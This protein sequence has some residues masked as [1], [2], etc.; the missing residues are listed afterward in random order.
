[1][2]KTPSIAVIPSGYKGAVSGE[3]GTVYS[4]LPTNGDA[5]LDFTRNCV[6]TRVNQNGLLE[7][8]GLNV[9][10]LDYSDGGCPSLL[11]EPSSTNLVPYS[12]DFSQWSK[13][14][15]NGTVTIVSNNILSPKGENNATRVTCNLVDAINN[16]RA[17][18]QLYV[19][20]VGANLSISIYLK[21]DNEDSILLRN[22][23]NIGQ[24]Q[25]I[26]LTKEWKRYDISVDNATIGNVRVEFGLRILGGF[27]NT[28]ATFDVFGVQLE[29]LPYA[30]S[31]IP[32][33]GTIE[34]RAKDAAS[35]S[36]L[37]NYINSSEGV[38]YAE[39]K[40]LA[41]SSDFRIISISDNSTS[42]RYAIGFDNL[43]RVYGFSTPSTLGG[44]ITPTDITEYFKVA[45]SFK[46]GEQKL[47]INGSQIGSTTTLTNLPTNLN[48]IGFDSGSG[49]S[50]LY[51]KVK[52]LR[53]YTTVLTD[54]ELTDLTS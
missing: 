49:G 28:S 19:A 32:T 20:D 3:N 23:L 54:Q 27:T 37:S 16:N 48:R 44:S 14:E 9:P 13:S 8:V 6:A 33:N 29:E 24:Y 51:G 42:N 34:T 12:E 10:R 5:D 43:N 40:G 22:P 35:K 47:F 18:F 53:V 4:V 7:E 41:D 36:G 2:S 50:S 1:M 21:S 26:Q 38:F 46:S 30:T 52:D 17:L 25:T 39:I 11:L 45:I 31:Y 15:T